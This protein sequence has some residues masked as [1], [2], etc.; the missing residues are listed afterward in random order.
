MSCTGGWNSRPGPP[1]PARH[2]R[3]CLWAVRTY[4]RS[5]MPF[6]LGTARGILRESQAFTH[7]RGHCHYCRIHRR[8]RAGRN[9]T[10]D[11]IAAFKTAA[12]AACVLLHCVLARQAAH[13]AAVTHTAGS[14]PGISA[15]MPRFLPTIFLPHRCPGCQ[16]GRSWRSWRSETTLPGEDVAAQ[17]VADST[18]V[19]E[20]RRKRARGRSGS[21]PGPQR[22]ARPVAPWQAAARPPATEA[23]RVPSVR[24]TLRAATST[25]ATVRSSLRTHAVFE[26]ALKLMA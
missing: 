6:P 9:C 4:R 16:R 13:R 19:P 25:S 24:V 22:T 18:G 7:T 2:R 26:S 11:E 8:R 17:I 23:Q 15:M 14:R 20:R 5:H 21:C 12:N 1:R 10:A 3:T